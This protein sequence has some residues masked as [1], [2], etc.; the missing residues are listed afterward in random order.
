MLEDFLVSRLWLLRALALQIWITKSNFYF[1]F[2]HL[3][4]F[5]IIPHLILLVELIDDPSMDLQYTLQLKVANKD[6]PF[7]IYFTFLFFD[8]FSCLSQAI[9]VV[10]LIFLY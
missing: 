7:S 8:Y 9:T 1:V 2:L 6:L 3:A 4:T 10:S 5:Q